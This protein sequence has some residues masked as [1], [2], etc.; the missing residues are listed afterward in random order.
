[1]SKVHPDYYKNKDLQLKD[2]WEAKF[3][4]AEYE[5]MCKIHISKYLYRAEYKNGLEDYQKALYYLDELIKYESKIHPE[6]VEAENVNVK[7]PSHYEQGGLQILDVW[8]NKAFYTE[9]EFRGF[10]KANVSKYVVRAGKKDPEKVLEDLNKA[11]VYLTWIIEAK[12]EEV[13]EKN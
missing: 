12:K 4:Q 13:K 3:S 11:R 1:M 7:H 2:V 8:K 6:L 9:E 5:G 10:C